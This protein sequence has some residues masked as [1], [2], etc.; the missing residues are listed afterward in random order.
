[1]AASFEFAPDGRTLIGGGTLISKDAPA[2]GR[3][4]GPVYFWKLRR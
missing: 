1:M 3:L 2:A 4:S